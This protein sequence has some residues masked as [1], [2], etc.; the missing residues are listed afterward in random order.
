M[1]R[2]LCFALLLIMTT[3]SSLYA[4]VITNTAPTI[5][6]TTAGQT[7]FD[8][9]RM[10]VFTGVKI[11]DAEKDPML[12]WVQID[13][14]NKGHFSIASLILSGFI[15]VGNG[16][17]GLF[18]VKNL[19]ASIAIRLLKFVPKENRLKP[20][21]SETVYFKIRAN[22]GEFKTDNTVTTVIVTSVNDPVVLGKIDD[23]FCMENG[24]TDKY[25]LTITDPDK[26]PEIRCS[27]WSWDESILSNS[28][29][30]FHGSGFDTKIKL[31]PNP[32]VS[33]VCKVSIRCSDGF[34]EDIKTFTLTV[35][36]V[37]PVNLPPVFD[38]VLPEITM[39]QCEEYKQPLIE[40]IERVDDPDTPDSL[41]TFEVLEDGHV[42][43]NFSIEDTCLFTA[44]CDWEGT[45]TLDVV[46]T[47]DGGKTDTTALLIH[48]LNPLGQ[49]QKNARSD[50]N[51]GESTV[52]EF[53]LS[54]NYPNPFNPTTTI[55]F[56]LPE[57]AHVRITVYDVTGRFVAELIN[58]TR[59]AGSYSVRW[60]AS[61]VGA[62]VY[63]YRIEAGPFTMMRK[64]TIM[65]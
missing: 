60:D 24:E 59:P 41:L 3:G 22:D 57:A 34:S 47:D 19:E 29:I 33:G 35:N 18:N 61:T 55:D 37:G 20:G 8:N 14:K 45:D 65:K 58:E 10:R 32:N 52:P 4:V 54:Q 26:D 63:F 11:I 40:W 5:T 53:A 51:E 17:Y 13:D 6:G 62:G 56:S 64:A 12:I 27:G 48:V 16:T 44:P 2:L 43:H 38:Q 21:E 15:P 28:G 39:N 31:I 23:Q 7:M 30:H 36:P 49:L 46:V 42:T 50:K 9:E 25:Q 1:K